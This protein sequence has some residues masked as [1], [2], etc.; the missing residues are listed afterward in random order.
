MCTE[1][2]ATDRLQSGSLKQQSSKIFQNWSI[3]KL[4]KYS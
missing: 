2:T 1:S 3:E 4:E